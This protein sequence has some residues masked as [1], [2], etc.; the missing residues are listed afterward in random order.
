MVSACFLSSVFMRAKVSRRDHGTQSFFEREDTEPKVDHRISRRRRRKVGQKGKTGQT[1]R[2]DR[3]KKLREAQHHNPPRPHRT[4]PPL[5]PHR[6]I[7]RDLGPPLDSNAGA[8]S[9]ARPP[10]P[11]PSPRLPAAPSRIT[12]RAEEASPKRGGVVLRARE[13][14]RC[15]AAASPSGRRGGA[16]P[17]PRRCPRLRA[18]R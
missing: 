8:P 7:G 12:A 15:S 1:A 3:G 5:A 2:S 13:P 6:W 16:G 9:R 11:C 10:L 14:W 17:P 4:A 18:Q